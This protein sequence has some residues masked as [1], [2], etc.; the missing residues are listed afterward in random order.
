MF[1]GVN[2]LNLDAK[3]RM[4]IPAKHREGLTLSGIAPVVLTINPHSSCLWLYP[5]SEWTEIA[6]KVSALPSMNRQYQSVKRL[7]LGYASEA[8]LDAQGRV[9]LSPELRKHAGLDKK[10]S[11]VGQGNKFEIWDAESWASQ[12]EA[13]LAEA[14]VPDSDL[15]DAFENIEF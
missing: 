5:E 9:L 3:G 15:S 10:I 13:W 7:L 14:Q 1:L 8:V 2:T 6:R 11:L 12:S 4:A